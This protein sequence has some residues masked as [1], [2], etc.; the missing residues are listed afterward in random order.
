MTI[1]IASRRLSR[2]L[3]CCIRLGHITFSKQLIFSFWNYEVSFVFEAKELTMNDTKYTRVST[4]ECGMFP[5][6][7]IVDIKFCYNQLAVMTVHTCAKFA[8]GIRD[9][10]F[11]NLIFY[12]FTN[13]INFTARFLEPFSDGQ[14]NYLYS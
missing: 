7:K 13:C 14:G 11:M 1:G 2:H 5:L 6:L 9:F 12:Q 8:R 10:S 3:L 4:H